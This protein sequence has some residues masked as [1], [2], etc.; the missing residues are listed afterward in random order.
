MRNTDKKWQVQRKQNSFASTILIIAIVAIIGFSMT[1]CKEPDPC[2]DCLKIGATGPGDGIIIYHKHAGF[3]VTELGT[4]Y[5]LEA[6]PDNQA[7]FLIWST[8]NEHVTGATGTAIGTGKANTDAI[9]AAHSGD[10][11]SNNAAKAAVAYTDGGKNDWFL[12]SKDELNEMYKAKNHLGISSGEFWSSSQYNY[13]YAWKQSFFYGNQDFS[14]KYRDY[15][16][17]AIRAF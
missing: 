9:I 12:P 1:A 16:V 17:R 8:T 6:A 11:A 13:N 14:D 5:Y 15:G 4:C 10:T 2:A 7:Q 3:T